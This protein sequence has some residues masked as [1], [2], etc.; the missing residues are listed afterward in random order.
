MYEMTEHCKRSNGTERAWFHAR[1]EADAFA[2]SPANPAYHGDASVREVR[3][4]A[5][6]EG[7]VAL[8]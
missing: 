2:Q 7:F 3:I 6:I 1:E 5:P 8:P 4:L